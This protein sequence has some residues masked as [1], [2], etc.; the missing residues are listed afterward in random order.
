MSQRQKGL[1]TS[2]S[3]TEGH[4]TERRE[5]EGNENAI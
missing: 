2:S 4:K 1:S 5:L 3:L